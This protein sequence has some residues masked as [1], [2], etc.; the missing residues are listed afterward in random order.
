MIVE[1]MTRNMNKE[2]LILWLCPFFSAVS[3]YGLTKQTDY[4]ARLSPEVLNWMKK[5]TGVY[6]EGIN[7]PGKYIHCHNISTY[8][9]RADNWRK[10]GWMV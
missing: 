2:V 6:H 3:S 8:F 4:G 10:F 9:S 5:I 1:V 7:D